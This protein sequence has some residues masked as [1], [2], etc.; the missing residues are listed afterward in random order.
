M[1]QAR[2]DRFVDVHFNAMLSDPLTEVRRVM[3][4]LDMTPGPADD[5]AWEAYLEQNRA[6]RHG[7]HSYTAED[8]G[9]SEDRLATDFAFYTEAYL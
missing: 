4:A 2:P 9:L 8:F 5:A 3:S 1:R 7:S 6:E